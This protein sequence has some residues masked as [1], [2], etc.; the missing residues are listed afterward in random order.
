MAE[1]LKAATVIAQKIKSATGTGKVHV[2]EEDAKTLMKIYELA[3]APTTDTHLASEQSRINMWQIGRIAVATEQAGLP[4][5][6]S[7]RTHRLVI[8]GYYGEG[9]GTWEKFQDI[10][11]AVL[12]SMSNLRQIAKT[13]TGVEL[14]DV[15]NFQVGP[16]GHATIGPY[17]CHSAEMR[18]D[19]RELRKGGN[20]QAV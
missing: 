8:R 16:I 17:S 20:I 9:E 19:V 6:Q 3:T 13:S 4:P 1:W 18:V 12:D 5:Q 15:G 14:F 10:I 7:W 2:G 11:D